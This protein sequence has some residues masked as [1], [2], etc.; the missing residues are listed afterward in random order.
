MSSGCGKQF[1]NM[2]SLVQSKFKKHPRYEHPPVVEVALGVQ[3][4]PLATLGIP[5]LGLLWSTSRARFPKVEHQPPLQH[6]IER[7]GVQ[8]QPTIGF[9]I[10]EPGSVLIPRVWMIS[11]RGTELLQVQQDRFVRNWRRYHDGQAIYPEYL[12][13]LRPKMIEDLKIFLAFVRDEKL[14]EIEFD[15]CDLTYVN[16]IEPSGVWSSPAEYTKVFP[17]LAPGLNVGSERPLDTVGFRA[18]HELLDPSGEFVGRLH[19]QLDSGT[20]I[21]TAERPEPQ[22]ILA[23]QLIARGS[24]IGK[25][26][27][28]L[29]AFLDFGHDAIVTTF[30][31]ITSETMHQAW[32]KKA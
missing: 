15:Q 2:S 14:G 32:G 30:D 22:P 24:P 7:R 9:R 20:S 16:Q 19:I 8:A 3:F 12:E 27:D 29:L 25:G 31:K 4:K 1:V 5:Q 21:P 11:E 26:I 17:G 18:R 10:V 13:H 28:G 6:E 23:L